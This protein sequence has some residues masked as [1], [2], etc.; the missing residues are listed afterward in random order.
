MQ[1]VEN[2]VP[3]HIVECMNFKERKKPRELFTESHR[4]LV[5]AGESSMKDTATSCTVVGALIVTIMFAAAFTVPGG[6]NG[7]TGAPMF[8]NKMLF[9]V[10]IVS[11]AISLFSSTTSV[12]IFL[13]IFTSRYAEEDFLKSLP[14]KMIFG[15]LTLF[16]SVTSMMIAFASALFIMRHEPWIVGPVSFLASVPILTFVWMQFP[17][18]AA[19]LKSTYGRGI[20]RS[21]L[22][23]RTRRTRR[24]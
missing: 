8:I 20:F 2:I 12:M 11:D 7:N 24:Q 10:F 4:E 22:K 9:M 3:S 15:L 5:K 21:K 18:F 13:G 17:L 19:T 6:N 1:E 14:K 16:I 23:R